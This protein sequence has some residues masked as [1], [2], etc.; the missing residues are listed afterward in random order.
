MEGRCLRPAT[1]NKTAPTVVSSP[2][3]VNRSPR[4]GLSKLPQLR[5][6]H[7]RASGGFGMSLEL[8]QWF[9]RRAAVES[10]ARRLLQLFGPR[11]RDEARAAAI[12][13]LENGG[14]FDF[15]VAVA[16]RVER[17][18]TEHAPNSH[19]A[20]PDG[21]GGPAETCTSGPSYRAAVA[22]HHYARSQ[23]VLGPAP[24]G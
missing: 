18:S 17:I 4:K 21:A 14:D 24:E 5:K 13:M 11:A 20:Q 8:L 15:H 3:P 9:Q 12:Y 6:A 10:H 23:P 7:R 2:W 19:A 1:Q 22:S 16:G